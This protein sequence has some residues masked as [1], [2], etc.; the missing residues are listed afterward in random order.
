MIS[1]VLAM[2]RSLGI[3]DIIVVV[4]YQKNRVMEALKEENVQFVIQEEQLGTAHAVMAARAQLESLA[5]RDL[6]IINGDLPIL[7]AESLQPLIDYH[8][9]EENALTF[10]TSI[11][12]NPYGFGRVVEVSSGKYRVIEEREASPEEKKIKQANVGIYVFRIKDLLEALPQVKNDNSKGEYYLTDLIEILSFRGKKVRPFAL[13]ESEEIVGVNDRFEL[14]QAIRLL[15]ERKNRSLCLKG[16]TLLDPGSIWVEMEVEIEPDTVIWPGVILTGR[17]KIGSG[18]QIESF[19]VIRDSILGDNVHILPSSVIEGSY[20]ENDT[21]V[22]PF[23]HLRPGTRLHRGARVGNFVEMKKTD[24]GPES[25]ALHL[26][27][28]GDSKVGQRVNIGAGTITCN[29]DGLKKHETVIEDEVFV[30]SGTQLVAPVKVGQGAYIG[31]GS[32]ITKNVSPEALAVARS[33]QIEKKGWAKRR[34]KK[35]D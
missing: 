19:S 11:M 30:G 7:R 15:Q 29:Y 28:L 18:C 1:H 12:D 27:Y 6:L 5:H 17:T 13:P 33:R 10:V 35:K 3:K 32:T 34:K 21:R 9:R 31:A 4:G 8:Q 14:A 24:F 20:L 25:K 16:V 22:G 2:V 23:S 26:S